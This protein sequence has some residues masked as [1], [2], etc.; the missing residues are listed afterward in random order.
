M[1]PGF[2]SVIPLRERHNAKNYARVDAL[3]DGVSR[4]TC[5]SGHGQT[6]WAAVP[7]GFCARGKDNR[8]TTISRALIVFQDLLLVPSTFG[9]S[10][11]CVRRMQLA[12]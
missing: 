5:D 6:R 12:G 8:I 1:T 9:V 2:V 10:F 7:A 11:P 4:S 3:G